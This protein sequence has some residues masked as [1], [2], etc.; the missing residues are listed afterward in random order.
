[1]SEM[2]GKV[3]GLFRP[4][5]SGEPMEALDAVE[6]IADL[7]FEG[8]R[9]GRPGSKRQVLLMDSETIEEYGFVPGDLD[10]NITTQGLRV[11]D[12]ERGQF[13]Q[14]GDVVL[15]VTIERPTCHKLDALRPGLGDELRGR[16]GKMTHVVAGGTIR[17]GD[18][19]RRPTT[20]DR[21]PPTTDE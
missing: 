6:V 4:G 5:A 2:Q 12:L 7:G 18:E 9:K 10:E 15:E 20:T 14:I 21:R 19:I 8:D 13:V 1:M 16:R 17:V 11:R 3:V